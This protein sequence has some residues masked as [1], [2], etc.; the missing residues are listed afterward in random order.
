[1]KFWKELVS[2]LKTFG[3]MFPDH[4]YSKAEDD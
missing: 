2:F 3:D 4:M 1:M